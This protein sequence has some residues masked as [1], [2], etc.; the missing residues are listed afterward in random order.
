MTHRH[1]WLYGIVGVAAL[2][3]LCGSREGQR[4][5]APAPSS[6]A[7]HSMYGKDLFEFYCASCHGRDGKGGGPVV[8]ALTT[9]PP[10]LTTMAKRNGGVF[11]KARVE[12][13]MTGAGASGVPVAHGTRE[14]PVWGPI[15]R[16]LDPSDRRGATRV[17]NLTAHLASLQRR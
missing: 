14:M 17:E 9:A 5:A 1:P 15:F 10:D 16:S 7:I 3:A 11:P 4:P 8:P 12:A 2:L 6:L 13:L